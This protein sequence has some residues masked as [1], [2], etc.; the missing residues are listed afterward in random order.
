M[1]TGC[2]QKTN[3][4]PL[5]FFLFQEFPEDASKNRTD[6]LL[7]ETGELISPSSHWLSS[8]EKDLRSPSGER[9]TRSVGIF[10]FCFVVGLFFFCSVHVPFKTFCAKA[11]KLVPP[12]RSTQQRTGCFCALPPYRLRDST[13][14]ISAAKV[15]HGGDEPGPACCARSS[16]IIL[17]CFIQSYRLYQL[18]NLS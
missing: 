2:T 16:W 14:H 11:D 7:L 6:K 1:Q 18:M 5:W 9:V 15:G 17:V 3:L 4:K 10:C 13:P 8:S 12:C